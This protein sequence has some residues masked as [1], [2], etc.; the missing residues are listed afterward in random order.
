[1]RLASPVKYSNF[2]LEQSI[3]SQRVNYPHLEKTDIMTFIASNGGVDRITPQGIAKLC[4][5]SHGR[6]VTRFEQ[7][8]QQKMAE[9][10]A[11]GGPAAPVALA[12]GQVPTP[13]PKQIT[14]ANAPAVLADRIRASTLPE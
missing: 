11:P 12:Q 9:M 10:Q 5:M 1:M 3:E 14:G 7:Y 8:H 4:K 2:K 6:V 13:G